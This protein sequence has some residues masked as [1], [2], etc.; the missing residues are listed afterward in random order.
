MSKNL[1]TIVSFLI[2]SL[3]LAAVLIGDLFVAKF[4]DNIFV[5]DWAFIKSAMMIVSS[6]CLLGYDVLFV[7]DVT[8]IKRYLKR[9]VIQA[10]LISLLA[11][12]LINY[13][14]KYSFE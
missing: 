1:G 14:T 11:V 2:Y 8:L 3:G 7:R 5:A 10:V 13:F 6:I 9:F 12:I 4:F